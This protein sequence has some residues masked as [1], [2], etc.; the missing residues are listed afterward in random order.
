MKNL[1][2]LLAFA[3]LASAQPAPLRVAW[4]ETPLAFAGK[5]VIVDLNNGTRIQGSWATVADD[6]FTMRVEKT[7]RSADVAKGAQ[8]LS[9]SSI[10]RIRIE[11]RRVRGRVIGTL[12][13]FYAVAGIASAAYRSSEALQGGWGIAAIAGGVLGYYTGRSIDRSTREVLL[14]P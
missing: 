11:N 4:N 3:T 5:R 6:V 13:G 1:A 9:R 12:A 8:T 2:L 7:S 10:K 14:E